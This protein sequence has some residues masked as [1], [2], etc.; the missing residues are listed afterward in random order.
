M[1][2]ELATAYVTLAIET[3]SISKS[4]GKMFSGV[5]SQ[6]GKTGRNMGRSMAESFDKAKPDMGRLEADLKRSQDRVV[7]HKE[8]GSRKMEAA[9]RKV[10]IAQ[11]RLNEVTEKYGADSSQALRAQDQLITAQQKAEAETLK[12]N[13][14]LESLEAQ[15]KDAKTALDDATAGAEK[16]SGVWGRVSDKLA[17]A[18]DKM[19]GIGDRFQAAG[20]QIS[21]V[22]SD[23]TKKITLP[24]GGAVTAAAGLTAALG[25]K[26]LVGIDTAQ[27][28]IRGLGYDVEKVMTDVDKGVTDTALSMA[29]GAAIARAALATGGVETGKELEE[30]I[31]RVANVS[32]AYGVESSHA[33]YLLNNVLTKGKVTYGDLSQ[34]VQNQIPIIS[35]L[36]DH[37]GVT[38]D[39]IE[40]MAQEGKISI[41]DLNEV[42]DKQAGAAAEE[43]SNSWQ[44]MTANIRSNL[45]KLGAEALVGVF[46][47]LKTEAGGFL[48]VLRSDQAKEIAQTIG[49]KLG[50]AF[51]RVAEFVR[52]AV[53]WF[54]NL[55]PVWQKTLLGAVGLAVALGPILIVV[56]K[57]ATGIGALI[58]VAGTLTSVMG[59]LI[60][61]FRGVQL[62]AGASRAA[63]IAQSVATK[64]VAGAQKLLNAVMRA[65]P[66][67]ILVTAVLALVG[68]FIYLWNTNEGFREFFIN[69]WQGI[70]DF[71]V[72][73]WD[74]IK[75]V[76][77]A[78]IDWIVDA[79]MNWTVYGL[80]IQNWDE[81]VGFFADTWENIKSGFSDLGS[82]FADRGSDITSA[83]GSMT[84]SLKEKASDIGSNVM[85]FLTEKMGALRDFFTDDST[86]IGQK[87]NEM[88]LGLQVVAT[89]IKTQ[90]FDTFTKAF[91][92]VRSLF[93]GDSNRIK[94]AWSNL[95]TSLV[96]TYGTIVNRVTEP[97][98]RAFGVVGDFF[99]DRTRGLREAWTATKNSLVSV[100]DTYIKPM[101]DRFG[102]IVTG[103]GDKFE[104][105]KN[106]IKKAWDKIKSVT[107][108]P[109][110]FVIDT[111]IN[112]G[113]VGAF[114]TLVGWIPG[115]KKLKEV[116]IAGF[117][118][119]GYTGDGG[120][121]EPAGVVHRGEYVIPKE[122]TSAIVRSHGIGALEYMRHTGRLPG[123]AGGGLVRPVNGRFTSGFGASRGRYPHAG[124]D[125]AVPIGTAVRA[126]LAGTVLGHQPPGRTGRYVFL[127][128]PGNRNTYYGHLSRP[129][130]S[131]GDSVSKGQVIGLSGNTGNSTGPHLHFETWTGGKPVD[132]M[133]YMGG[134]P[135]SSDGGG[136]FSFNPLQPLLDLVGG[137]AGKVNDAFSA[138]GRFVDA[139]KGFGKK[140]FDDIIDWAKSKLDFFGD[141]DDTGSANAT[142]AAS[143]LIKKQVQGVAEGFGW[144]SG[145]QWDAL[146]QIIQ[147]ESSWNLNA[148]NPSSSARGL[149]QKMTSIHG[150]VESDAAGQ[151]GWGLKYIRD[152]YGSPSRALAHHNAR[153]WY[154][155]GGLVRD[156]GGVVPPGSSVIH[157][158]TRDP[159]WMYTNK[160]QDTVQAALD[161]LKDGAGTSVNFYGPTYM[162][163]EDQFAEHYEARARR[164]RKVS[165]V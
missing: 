58:G 136:G 118:G 154:A 69:L 24:I 144:G 147:R 50:G 91:E 30:Q 101:F 115:V 82:W 33:G 6:A 109:I 131:P 114:N 126:A 151:A 124:V 39:E 92:L 55:S 57:I 5:E 13:A 60:A 7:A 140:V 164:Q 90:V 162:R 48:E 135:E 37:Y 155:D 68:V 43:Y 117:S 152:R 113:L 93:S 64:L 95:R 54:T 53:E 38:G 153:G 70:A 74:G 163:D 146:S 143:G 106:N 104:T 17:Q 62:A 116:N 4:V 165:L 52:T 59:G 47:T 85:G 108:A 81:I 25:F 119:G 107:K 45:G 35:A 139:A 66:I 89:W 34:M 26:R 56:G 112:K 36:A 160:Q 157:N 100:Y 49:E 111:V 149:F 156:R 10:E 137:L 46:E 21:D 15:L 18:G 72:G 129:M 128:H 63:L 42:L 120:K 79:F 94:E 159:E 73:L 161:V 105:A 23:L 77:S 22:G 44:G 145:A 80:I 61:G 75:N 103:L 83:W 138:G 14:S 158:W 78:A 86:W 148:A 76:F 125:W 121:H 87:F 110:K 65:N 27:A 3:S 122:A 40:K 97:F 41:E 102:E 9:N 19:R 71:F 2:V 1:A 51:K 29:D 98:K 96:D 142:G 141:P 11:A 20:R 127:S 88:S 132:P 133:K 8:T 67:G 123:Y 84:D 16:S 134:L 12:Y 28:Q 130:V 150:P 32:A 31:R 99:R